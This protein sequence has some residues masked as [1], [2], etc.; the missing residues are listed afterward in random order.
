MSENEQNN[1]QAH[2]IRWYKRIAVLGV[3]FPV[4]VVLWLVAGIVLV[5]NTRGKRL[6]TDES[7]RFIEQIGN[8]AVG[9][10]HGRLREAAAMN[11][12][13]ASAVERLP[14]D[15]DLVMKVVPSIIDFRGDRGVAGGGVWPE[16]R[17]FDGVSERFSFFWGRGD[18]GKLAF[19]DD[20]NQPG[21]GYHREDWYVVGRHDRDGSG[22]WSRSYT[23]PVSGQPMVTHTQPMAD[24]EGFSGVTTV[25]LKIE[26]M[27]EFSAQWGGKLDG[28]VVILDP[29]NRFI[30]FP[31]LDM[32]RKSVGTAADG[33][34]QWD[35]LTL[36]EVAGRQPLLAPLAEQAA[37]MDAEILRRAGASPDYRPGVAEELFESSSLFTKEA[38]GMVAAGLVD[39]LRGAMPD[40]KL[41]ASYETADDL[42]LGKPSVGFV[43]HV[44]DSY[45]KLVL[46]TTQA[47]AGAVAGRIVW[48]L[49]VYVIITVVIIFAVAVYGINRGFIRPL[50]SLTRAVEHTGELVSA[51]RYESLADNPI[52]DPGESEL[53]RL[54]AVFNSLTNRVRR[55]HVRLKEAVEEA[56]AGLQS[57]MKAAETANRAKSAFLANMS[58]ELRTPMN[59]II[60]YSEMLMEEAEDLGQDDFIPDLQKIHAAGKHLLGLINDVLDISK[61]EAGKMTV[62][63]EDIDVAR[64]V[65]EIEGTVMPLIQKNGN[66]LEVV[67][68]GD[69]GRMHSDLTKIRQTLF[70]LLSNA[71]KFTENGLIRMEVAREGGGDGDW[72][73]FTVTDSGI[74]MTPDQLSKLFQS[75]TQ[76]D[77]S[78]TRKYGGTGL[79]LAISR[80]FCQML[81]GDIT[82]TSVAG[83]GSTFV[84]KLPAEAPKQA[85]PEA[86]AVASPMAIEA[87]EGS[88]KPVV[89]VIDDDADVRDLMSRFLAR[90]GYIPLTASNGRDGVAL[91][92]AHNPVA[93]TTDVMMPGMDGWSVISELKS[94]PLTADIPV[95]LL[96]ITDTREMGLAL[97]VSDFLSKPV[98][99]NRLGVILKRFGGQARAE[100]PV[101]VVEDDPATREL[102]ERGLQRDGWRVVT[103]ANGRLGLE[104][105]A[106]TQPAMVLLDLMMPEMDGFEFLTHF[107]REARFAS[108]PVIILTAKDLTDEDRERLSGKATDLIAKNGFVVSDLIPKIR[109]TVNPP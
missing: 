103:A 66:R 74:G 48:M 49:M 18:D 86:V 25:D 97:G 70:N 92:R 8:D 93:I 12:S 4:V 84:V 100:D 69:A 68:G 33:R 60:G 14:R 7:Y 71:S 105:L 24:E 107:R 90:E 59:A 65:H 85:Q 26:G 2:S 52:P 9:G 37:R 75:F 87:P 82:V 23:D 79:G 5:M 76:A 89:V 29:A 67:L 20:Y 104:V 96:T 91:A 6:V 98:D 78:T 54:A 15:K 13:L 77:A 27:E 53:G 43:F 28:Y 95:I 17:R 21:R 16:P 106:T 36:S 39:P 10:L 58:H 81:G 1:G 88:A 3:L 47:R 38:A 72:L 46:V 109:A 63:C 51:G 56:T 57:A 22:F 61:I 31:K 50:S 55:E 30:S 64:M 40:S 35:F 99:W 42:L 45:W 102:L 32:V 41:F 44:P 80:K 62:F 94:D 83:E 73:K 11:R 34:T 108:V 19:F 101:L